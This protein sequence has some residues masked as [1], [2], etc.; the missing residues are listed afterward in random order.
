V[1]LLLAASGDGSPFDMS[2]PFSCGSNAMAQIQQECMETLGSRVPKTSQ[3]KSIREQNTHL[4]RL[5]KKKQQMERH[6]AKSNPQ[7]PDETQKILDAALAE[8]ND[9]EAFYEEQ[10][11]SLEE[12]QG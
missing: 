9:A 11:S 2:S 6:R 3:L 1:S 5:Q 12:S 8:T 4:A 7:P 10:R